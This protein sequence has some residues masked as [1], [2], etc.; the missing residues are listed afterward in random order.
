MFPIVRLTDEVLSICEDVP[1]GVVE[2]G[3]PN[4][5]VDGLPAARLTD[6]STPGP[7]I[8]GSTKFFVDGLPLCRIIDEVV[9]GII[10]TASTNQYCD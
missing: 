2:S 9:C 4:Y 6:L 5:F 7:I 8:T 1:S 10:L 3:S